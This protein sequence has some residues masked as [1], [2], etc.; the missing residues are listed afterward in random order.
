MKEIAIRKVFGA[1]GNQLIVLLSKPFFQMVLI[2]NIIAWPVAFLIADKWL[3][4]FAYR[5]HLSVV[6]FIIAFAISIAIV[7]FTVCLQII[8]A[9][10]FNPAV[11]LKV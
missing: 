5:V 2:A 10:K 6:P 8:K 9:V 3:Q 11:R 7:V 4:T 1:G